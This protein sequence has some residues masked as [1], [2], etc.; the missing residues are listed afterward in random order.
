MTAPSSPKKAAPRPTWW[1]VARPNEIFVDLD[2]G[3]AISR[4]L[5]VVRRALLVKPG[6]KT[7]LN[8]LPI[9]SVWLYPSETEGHAHLILKLKENLHTLEKIS[10]S[11]WMGTDQIRAAYVIERLDALTDDLKFLEEHSD[12]PTD[13]IATREEYE[14]RKPDTFCFCKDKH[15]K[16]SVTDKC[17]ALERILGSHRS[18]DYFPRNRDTKERDAVRFPWGKVPLTNLRKWSVPDGRK[19]NVKV[20]RRRSLGSAEKTLSGV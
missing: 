6:A 20:T 18:D 12:I 8:K 16:K 2:S 5:S 11:L 19:S 13:L 9:E 4:A 1:Y 15:K 10:W 7:P 17:D 14:F 3:G